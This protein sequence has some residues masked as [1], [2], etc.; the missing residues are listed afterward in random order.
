MCSLDD[1]T[2]GDKKE[3]KS[4]SRHRSSQ[5]HVVLQVTCFDHGFFHLKASISSDWPADLGPR[6][7]PISG[8]ACTRPLGYGYGCTV[9]CNSMS[10][11]NAHAGFVAMCSIELLWTCCATT[12]LTTV[13]N[14]TLLL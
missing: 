3:E 7:V 5:R 2:D 10:S 4:R 11:T 9:L 14:I 13:Q 6:L 1:W 8:K 12:V